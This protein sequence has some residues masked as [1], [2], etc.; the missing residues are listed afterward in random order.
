MIKVCVKEVHE[1]RE[2]LGMGGNKELGMG[3]NRVE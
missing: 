2:G 3:G 1:G